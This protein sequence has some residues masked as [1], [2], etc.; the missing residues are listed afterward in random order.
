M[1]VNFSYEL[2]L[3]SPARITLNR[4]TCLFT[5][6]FF[7]DSSYLPFLC[8]LTDSR[9]KM[10]KIWTANKVEH[11][12]A[13]RQIGIDFSSVLNLRDH[14]KWRPKKKK[15]GEGIML[16]RTFVLKVINNDRKKLTYHEM[17]DRIA[18]QTALVI[19]QVS[20]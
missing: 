15:Q 19:I 17:I 13:N 2:V 12:F 8:I 18:E 3:L 10:K 6:K 7:P 11:K 1:S 5:F 4:L 20:K 16:I 9:T 14:S